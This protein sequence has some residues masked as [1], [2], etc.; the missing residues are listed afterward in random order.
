MLKRIE[1]AVVRPLVFLALVLC[2]PGMQVVEAYPSDENLPVRNV[3]LEKIATGLASALEL[4]KPIQ[5]AI[6]PRNDNIVSVDP[7]LSGE[8]YRIEFE[9]Q[10]FDALDDEEITAALAHEIGHVW[11]FSHHP[12]LQ[13][14]ALANEIALKVV[15]RKPLENLY[16]KMWQYTGLTGNLVELLGAEK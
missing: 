12:Y 4:R 7:F 9:R 5:V 11:I 16:N 14:E 15:A 6:V 10:F 3:R 1:A 8:G 13:T 2:T